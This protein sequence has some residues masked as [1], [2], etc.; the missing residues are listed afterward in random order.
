VPGALVPVQFTNGRGTYVEPNLWMRHS[1]EPE[2]DV[3][4][5]LH[6]ER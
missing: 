2:P 5:A 4:P 3:R 1:V 6:W